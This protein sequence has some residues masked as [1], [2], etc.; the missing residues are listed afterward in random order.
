VARRLLTRPLLAAYDLDIEDAWRVPTDGPAIVAANHR[1]FMD[2]IFLSVAVP[3]PVAFLAKAEYFDDPR[4]AWLF[5]MTGQI[6]VR[7][8]SPAGARAAMD[9]ATDVLTRREVIALYPEGTRSRDGRLQRGTLG[10]ARLAIATSVPI[11]PVGLIGTE[12]VQPPDA[13]LPR[14]NKRVRIRFGEPL[15]PDPTLGERAQLRDL[16]YD[17]MA[18]IADLCGQQPAQSDRRQLVGVE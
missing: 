10:A 9:A 13:R 3:R 14:I 11:I 4:V 16:T 12:A 1:S 5:R 8:G 15:T 2:S 6:P 17:L 18:A 7:R